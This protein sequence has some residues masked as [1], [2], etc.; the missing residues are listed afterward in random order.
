MTKARSSRPIASS[1][2]TITPEMALEWLVANTNNR[3]CSRTVVQK[4]A[5]DMGAG[6]WLVNGDPI[7][8]SVNGVL[9]DGQHRLEACLEAGVPFT[10]V[11]IRGLPEDTMPTID[12][13]KKRTLGD[14]LKLRGELD[15][16]NLASAVSLGL[17]WDRGQLRDPAVPPV[18]ACLEWLA[19]NPTIRDEVRTVLPLRR[20]PTRIGPIVAAPFALRAREQDG[21]LVDDFLEVLRS[22]AN[23]A[24]TDAVYAFRRWL[25][26]SEERRLMVRP[27][28]L[29][30]LLIKTYNYWAQGVE[31]T[32]IR[33]AAGEAFPTLGGMPSRDARYRHRKRS[34]RRGVEVPDADGLE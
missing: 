12:Q 15:A 11:V 34:Q 21:E 26:R 25:V 13:G 18:T 1:I 24:E 16:N 9:L 4:Y 33:I 10:S 8:W 6:A 28:Q 20:A 22:G 3:T 27:P 29:L 30:G 2:E 5:E 17:K 14:V 31:I 7:R 32:Q 23:L 19:A